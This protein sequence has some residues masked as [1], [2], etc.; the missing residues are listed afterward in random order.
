MT[1]RPLQRVD[2]LIQVALRLARSV[3]TG[4]IALA[5][6]AEQIDPVW[7]PRPWGEEIV[8]ELNAAHEAAL[9]TRL[10]PRAVERALRTAWGC[11][12]AEELA[13]LELEPVA[14]TPAAQVH[15][16]VLDG[17]PVAIKLLRPGLASAVRQDLAVLDGLLGPLASAF[18]ALDARTV[19]GEIRER[20]LE[21]LDLEH[22][23]QNQR[24]FHRALRRHP[25]LSV[26]APVTRLANQS[27]LVSE[28]VD[29]T[30]ISEAPNRDLA[31]ARL[32]G[33]V[34]G[35]PRSGA[36]HVDPHPGDV[37]VRA[38]GGL[39]L[40]DFGLVR[41]VE[42][43]RFQ[44]GTAALDAFAARDEDGFGALAERLGWLE[45]KHAGLAMELAYHSLGKLVEP[46]PTLLDSAAVVAARDRLL[47]RAEDLARLLMAGSLP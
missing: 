7:V 39:A 3:P 18:P 46:E 2:A 11:K 9:A 29:G 35:A 36:M 31:A 28:W 37:R 34:L 27:V 42:A 14:V 38:D 43:G 33:F 47:E 22:E 12:P 41:S 19:L 32:V 10:E 20:V 8:A 44:I 21:E 16:G 13:E 26:P 4:R 6:L 25:V 30:P 45:A 1:P 17:R 24:R 23:A 5:R 40:L 15:R